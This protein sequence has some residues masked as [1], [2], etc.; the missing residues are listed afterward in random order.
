MHTLQQIA[1]RIQK[2]KS[3][4]IFMHMRPDGD[5]FG[6]ALSLSLALD[7]M[8]ISNQ[9]CVESDIPSNL[10]F[11]KNLD[12]VKKEPIGDYDLLIMVDCS[13]EE[14]LGIL[15]DEFLR[16][17]RKKITTINI[18]HHVSNTS[19]ADFNYVRVCSAN[20]M[21]VANLIDE[22]GV[23]MDKAMA[24]YLYT[25]LLTDSGNYSHDDVTDETFALASRLVGC[26]VDV[27][28]YN[29]MLFKRQT[30]ARAKLHSMTMSGLRYNLDGRMSCIVISKANME[31]CGADAGSTEGFVEFALNVDGVEVAVS[32]MEM[33]HR[34]YKVSL[35]S[36]E[37]VD[38]NKIAG[39]YGGGGH[40]RASGCMLF[41]DVEEVIDRLTYTVSQYLEN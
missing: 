20:C 10:K 23:K 41:G 31:L 38:V 32:L 35:R 36:K 26:G 27:R 28:Y 14:R 13:D 24:E 40:V 16:A 12:K 2:S 37:Y 19:Y 29:Y 7:A 18:D 34:Q 6:S 21:N 8:H 5:A 9:V 3:V 30:P 33:K 39:V 1:Q 4:A 11:L 25:G 17:K 22:L 15:T